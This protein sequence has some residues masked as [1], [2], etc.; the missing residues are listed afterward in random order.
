[1]QFACPRCE[2]EIHCPASAASEAACPA[3]GWRF[4][5]GGERPRPGEPVRVCWVCGNDEFYVQKDFNRQLGFA[6]V[7]MSFALI[8][9]VMLWKGH[10]AGVVLLLALGAADLLVF[11]RLR[12]VTVCYLC[13]TIYRGFPLSPEHRGFYLGREENYKHRRKEWLARLSEEA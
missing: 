7:V 8:F 9:L 13:H 1:M 2:E 6:I 4:D 3:C 12:N 10:L 5:A 11:L